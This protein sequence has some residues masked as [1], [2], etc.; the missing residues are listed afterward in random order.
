MT[1]PLSADQQARLDRIEAAPEAEEAIRERVAE[2]IYEADQAWE[3]ED[4]PDYHQPVEWRYNHAHRDECRRRAD[5]AIAVLRG[6]SVA[7]EAVRRV[8]E[9]CAEEEDFVREYPMWEINVA[10]PAEAGDETF[11]RICDAVWDAA[12]DAEPEQRDWEVF[13][14]AR[15][16]P[17]VVPV[18]RI[19][20]ALNGGDR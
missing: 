20:A 16:N 13:C 18:H 7:D 5:A 3:A 1:A 2:A 6:P 4:D 10:V 15:K 14:S 11:K 12:V 8:E 19:R 17:T 9:L